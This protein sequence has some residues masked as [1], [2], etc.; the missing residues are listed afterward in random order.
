MLTIDR[1]FNDMR[2]IFLKI[3]QMQLS[4]ANVDIKFDNNKFEKT[5]YQMFWEFFFYY[6]YF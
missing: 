5:N 3:I 6:F 1:H 4:I 2:L